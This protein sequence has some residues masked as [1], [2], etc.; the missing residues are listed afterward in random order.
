MNV[1]STSP[2]ACCSGIH[3]LSTNLGVLRV[4]MVIIPTTT[5]VSLMAPKTHEGAANSCVILSLLEPSVQRSF[6]LG[7]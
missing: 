3:Q 4:Y 7:V 1:K 6:E 5:T 2:E